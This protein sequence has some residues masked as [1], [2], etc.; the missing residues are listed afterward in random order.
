MLPPCSGQKAPGGD[1]APLNYV[2]WQT[3][4]P[5]A[6]CTYGKQNAQLYLTPVYMCDKDYGFILVEPKETLPPG[7]TV[8]DG[9]GVQPPSTAKKSVTD[10]ELMG[11]FSQQMQSLS[12]LRALQTKEIQAVI[13]GRD[14]LEDDAEDIIIQIERTTQLVDNFE[15]K[16]S[17]L[18]SDKDRILNGEGS[19]SEKKRKLKPVLI[20]IKKNDKM[21]KA[22]KFTL[23][24][25]RSE[26][27]KVNGQEED[28]DNDDDLFDGISIHSS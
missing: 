12:E 27:D 9:V 1:G 15:S 18:H 3:R 14:G 5:L 16:G 22:L 21:V 13:N 17:K 20:D 19:Q 11:Q 7:C 4:D 8:E 24:K 6:F 26:L 10:D 2:I 23:D 25:Q 28:G